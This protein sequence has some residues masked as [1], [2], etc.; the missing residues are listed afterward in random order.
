MWI[1]LLT[2]LEAL[3]KYV[4]PTIPVKNQYTSWEKRIEQQSMEHGWIFYTSLL[5]CLLP[6]N[7]G[8]YKVSH[9]DGH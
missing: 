7:T 4:E 9:E 8:L 3:T 6:S 1:N 2:D 5:L